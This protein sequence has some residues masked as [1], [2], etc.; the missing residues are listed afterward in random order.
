MWPQ[1]DAD[2]CR[3]RMKSVYRLRQ[4]LGNAN[5]V[6]TQAGRL[7]IDPGEIAVDA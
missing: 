5:A 7:L 3:R 2:G 6:L 1:V 4:M